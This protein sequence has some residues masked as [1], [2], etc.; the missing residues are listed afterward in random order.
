MARLVPDAARRL[1]AEAL[2]AAG[3][4]E[5]DAGLV[6]RILVRASARGVD[7][8]GVV[9]LAQYV[10][11]LLTGRVVGRAEMEWVV[12][13][14]AIGVLDAG[15]GMGHVAATRAMARAVDRALEFGVGAVA[16]RDSSHFG[17]AAE[18]PLQ[19][20]E[21]GAIGITWT[22][23]PPV[24]APWGGREPRLC[25]NPIAIGVP[26]ERGPLVLDIA[27]SVVAG[28]K[29]RLAHL[30]GE[31][32]PEG[33]ALDSDGEPTTDP[34]E[35]T[36]GMLLPIAGHKG[37][38][39]AFMADMLSGV[40]SGSAFG[41]DVRHQGAASLG[42]RV[43]EPEPPRVGH[44][45]LAL[46]PEAFAPDGA[47]PGR[48]EAFVAQMHGAALASGTERILV[49]GELELEREREGTGLEVSA[50]V[51]EGILAAAER[52]GVAAPPDLV[53]A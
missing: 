21:R 6:A 16:V 7:S 40:L 9:R 35:A 30:A 47:F 50:Q 38:G 27:M 48:L 25:N 45:L 14:G 24:M 26:S 20:A 8:H 19:A 5:A 4:E 11:N 17:P 10:D 43:G 2:V 52:V 41:A 22:N 32:I 3:M 15:N 42:M 33:W 18:Y 12:D 46:S 34:L 31:R 13:L 44:F 51:L 1:C 28:G 37:Y 39:M 53:A 29:I 49:P 36:E 23:G